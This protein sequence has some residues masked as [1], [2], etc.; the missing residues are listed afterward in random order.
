M[1]KAKKL[2][3]ILLLMLLICSLIAPMN[4][5]AETYIDCNINNN[6]I[7]IIT[8]GYYHIYGTGVTTTNQIVIK[9]DV[10]AYIRL[11][12]VKIH[13]NWNESPFVIEDDSR[14]NITIELVGDNELIGKYGPAI[15]KSSSND[16][17]GH[18][19][20]DGS[21]SLIAK[22]LYGDGAGIGSSNRMDTKNISIRGGTITATAGNYGAGIGGGGGGGCASN[23]QIMGGVVTA[24]GGSEQGAGIGG[25]SD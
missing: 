21:G 19:V 23:I 4:V 24:T 14:G 6:S 22:N 12:N 25:G 7:T 3:I 8:D 11:E 18:L 1:T 15:C 2:G 13:C 10:N 9:K 17:V 16:V 20:I 5:K